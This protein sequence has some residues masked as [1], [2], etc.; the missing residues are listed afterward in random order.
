MTSAASPGILNPSLPAGADAHSVGEWEAAEGMPPARLCWSDPQLLPDHLLRY[1]IRAV[2]QQWPDGAT[3]DPEV[4][5]GDLGLS[6]ADARLVA[7]ALFAA[8]DIG[9]R[10]ADDI[11]TTTTD[12]DD[13]PNQENQGG[14]ECRR[15]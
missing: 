5:V 14:T 10:M 3:T 13:H 7:R 11:P 2:V 9:D 1:D 8:A 15:Y 4:H 12:F 6:T